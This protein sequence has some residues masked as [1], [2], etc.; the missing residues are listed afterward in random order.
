MRVILPRPR[1]EA[2]S[3]RT[4][5]RAERL[6][7]VC[8]QPSLYGSKT[9][10][11]DCHELWAFED[12]DGVA[13]QRLVGVVGLCGACHETQ[14]S[15]LA[16]V[17]GRGRFVVETL[18]RVNGWTADEAEADIEESVK[19]WGQLT[20]TEWAL[21]LRIL[22][23]WLTLEGSSSLVFDADARASLGN[24]FDKVPRRLSSVVGGVIP[25]AVWTW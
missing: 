3:R 6:C 9:R 4:A 7:E 2:L 11:P 21:D 17:N 24:T 15:G 20:R 13:T 12:A 18:R 16:E 14:H 25:E 22:D 8:R 1:W 10:N 19:R 5:E 23:G